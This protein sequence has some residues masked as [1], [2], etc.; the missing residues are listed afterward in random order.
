MDV[1]R[2]ELE[3]ALEAVLHRYGMVAGAEHDQLV[4]DLAGVARGA[5][6]MTNQQVADY[7]GIS[8]ASVRAWCSRHG[9]HRETMTPADAV[10]KVKSGRPGKGW[11][12]G[13]SRTERYQRGRA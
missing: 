9:I 6:W 5:G 8:L 1:E 13:T 3:Q 12:A 11:R 10:R 2:T 4:R 7:V